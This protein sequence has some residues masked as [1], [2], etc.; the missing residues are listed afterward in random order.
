MIEQ[1][2]GHK[3][4]Q[5]MFF[6]GVMRFTQHMEALLTLR[7]AIEHAYVIYNS[8]QHIQEKTMTT[9]RNWKGKHI[10]IQLFKHSS[11]FLFWDITNLLQVM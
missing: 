4:T 7:A 1:I 10:T 11:S 2:T 3:K 8:K 5:R 6:F 9:T